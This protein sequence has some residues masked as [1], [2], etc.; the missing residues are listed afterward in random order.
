[1]FARIHNK[2]TRKFPLGASMTMAATTPALDGAALY[3][4]NCA[5][6]HG[7]LAT[8]SKKGATLAAIQGGSMDIS[9]LSVAQLQAISDA[10]APVVTPSPTPVPTPTPAPV[11][12]PTPAP[13]VDNHCGGINNNDCA[14]DCAKVN[15]NDKNQ[16]DKHMGFPIHGNNHQQ[17]NRQEND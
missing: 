7:P 8:S 1:M 2:R 16:H 3:A 9:A 17:N 5:G 13:G 14:K 15:H 4:T 6:C 12:T 10:L 11:P